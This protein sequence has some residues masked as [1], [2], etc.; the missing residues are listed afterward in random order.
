MNQI[1]LE[2]TKKKGKRRLTADSETVRERE[3]SIINGREQKHKAM[4]K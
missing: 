3:R 4:R 2:R 1:K